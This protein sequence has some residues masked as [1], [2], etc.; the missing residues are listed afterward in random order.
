MKIGDSFPSAYLKSQ[1]LAD[2]DLILTI[3]SVEAE[4]FQEKKKAVVYFEENEKGL[5]LNRT[6]ANAI[7]Q[8]YGDVIADWPGERIQ[9]FAT[10]VDFRG[11]QTL[12]IR[13]RLKKPDKPPIEV[14][15]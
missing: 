1:D 8:L 3:N 6:N 5:I 7:A 13:V 14:P 11:N 15:F 4:E 2:G 10:Q 12:A 9:L